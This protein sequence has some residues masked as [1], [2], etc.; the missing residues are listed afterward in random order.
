MSPDSSLFLD[1][2]MIILELH[3]VVPLQINAFRHKIP[4]GYTNHT[5][6]CKGCNLVLFV[7]LIALSWFDYCNG[8]IA[9][10]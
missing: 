1:G 3:E 2:N 9:E 6:F 8:I 10:G 7:D 5:S 4:S